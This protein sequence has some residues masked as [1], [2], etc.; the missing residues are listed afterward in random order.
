[1]TLGLPK[2]ITRLGGARPDWAL[3]STRNVPGGPQFC[4][5]T[6]KFQRVVRDGPGYRKTQQ[7]TEI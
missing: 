6:G 2:G 3:A 7:L 5:W 4:P 1:M